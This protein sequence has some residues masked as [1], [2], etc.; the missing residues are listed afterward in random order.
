MSD[1]P[2]GLDWDTY[3]FVSA[4]QYRIDVLQALEN[5]KVP[6]AISDDIDVQIS[7]V[8][9][10]LSELRDKDMVALLVDEDRKKGRVY[11]RTA[12][13]EKMADALAEMNE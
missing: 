7:H 8:S 6:S 5:P 12:M 1:L 10:T 9:R 2:D 13:G 3:G 11:G 4:S